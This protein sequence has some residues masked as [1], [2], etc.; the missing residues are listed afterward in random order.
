MGIIWRQASGVEG[1]TADEDSALGFAGRGQSILGEA[2]VDEAIN[3]MGGLARGNFGKFD[4]LIGP[5]AFFLLT[6]G[7]RKIAAGDRRLG[8]A[9]G[10]GRP[11]L[12]PILEEGNFFFRQP[13]AFGRHHDIGV[14]L[15]NVLK[16]EALG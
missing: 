11:S 9:L 10:P 8:A 6:D 16:E 14:G 12:N 7:A 5:P 13:F 1:D 2:G 15:E 4:G 3:R